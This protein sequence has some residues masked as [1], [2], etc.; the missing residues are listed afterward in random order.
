MSTVPSRMS[1]RNSSRKRST[2]K[3]SESVSDTWRPARWAIRGR[4]PE[5]IL[6][7]RPV[8]QIALEIGDRRVLDGGGVDIGRGEELRG[9][10]V[11]VHRPLAVGRDEDHRA[12]GR[13]AAGQRRRLEMDAEG[14]HVVA[15]DDAELVVGDLAD[16]GALAAER[17]DAG[18]GVAGAAAGGFDRRPHEAVEA[19]GLRRLDQAHR[20]LDEPLADQEVVLDAGEHVDNGVADAEDVEAGL[21]HGV[22]GGERS[23]APAL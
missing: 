8:P 10:E 7:V 19:L 9:A 16:E 21:R 13:V 23:G 1:A 15:V 11:G 2:Q 18:R 6:G 17:G 12:A 4:R 20:A 5:G 3:E 22:R 14:M